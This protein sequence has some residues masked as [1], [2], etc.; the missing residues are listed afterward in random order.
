MLSIIDHTLNYEE[1][2]KLCVCNITSQKGILNYCDNCPEQFG[3]KYFF[4]VQLLKKYDTGSSLNFKQSDSIDC[5]QLV[6]KEYD[7]H[8]FID[9]LTKMFIELNEHRYIAKKQS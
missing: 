1:V 5:T 4:T 2:I 6:E 7:F 9:S 8:K 3:I